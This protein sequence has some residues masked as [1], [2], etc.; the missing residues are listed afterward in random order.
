MSRREWYRE[1]RVPLQTLRARIDYGFCT[2]NTQMGAIGIQVWVYHGDVLPGQKYKDPALEG[3]GR[4]DDR[5]GRPR[6]NS[7]RR[8][9]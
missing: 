9:K 8:Q 2:A 5:G 6:R 4:R 1:G 3:S 7:D